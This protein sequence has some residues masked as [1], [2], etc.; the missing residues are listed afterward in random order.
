MTANRWWVKLFAR[1][2]ARIDSVKGQIQAV[3]LVVTAFST[4]SLVLQNA[5]LSEFILPLGI[6]IAVCGPIYAYY[7]FEAGVWNQVARDR[8]D[9]S[10]NFGSPS[11]WIGNEFTARAFAAYLKGEPLSEDEREVIQEEL[12]K[13]FEENRDG[14]NIE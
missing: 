12:R 14:K 11:Q 8:N 6:V 9:M 10:G 3:S 4:F 7:F 13:T 2:Q 1:W 5:G